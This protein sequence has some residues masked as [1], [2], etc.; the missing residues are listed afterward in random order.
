M[1]ECLIT[2]DS[3]VEI[4]SDGFESCFR[5]CEGDFKANLSSILTLFKLI[6][7][8]KL[9]STEMMSSALHLICTYLEGK[10]CIRLLL[11]LRSRYSVKVLAGLKI[12]DDEGKLP[13]HLAAE[14][15]TPDVLKFLL[16]AYPES[17]PEVTGDDENLLHL[18]LSNIK[19]DKVRANAKVRYLCERCPVLLHMRNSKNLTPIEYVVCYGPLDLDCIKIMCEADETI[20]SERCKSDN[21]GDNESLLLYLLWN[22][23][24]FESD[25]SVET[26]C[27]R[28][29]LRLYPAAVKDQ[30]DDNENLYEKMLE[31][32]DS[33]FLIRSILDADRTIDPERR[34]DL[35]YVARKEGMFLAFGAL[36]NDLNP[37]IWVKLRHESRDLL[38]HTLSFL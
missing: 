4:V 32:E 7:D 5:F 13:I 14:W 36:T 37:T 31:G 34:G 18:A 35:N 15:S 24:D 33:D 38:M 16:E 11:H 9:L 22:Y 19:E 29:L 1:V 27:F 20:V 10:F 17:L 3:S 23:N 28:F 2:A 26:S 30:S 21:V 25:V 8:K 6:D 12:C